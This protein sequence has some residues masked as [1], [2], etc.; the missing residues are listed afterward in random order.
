MT[1]KEKTS[2]VISK[3]EELELSILLEDAFKLIKNDCERFIEKTR[4]LIND[5]HMYEINYFS[6]ECIILEIEFQSEEEANNYIPN[7][8]YDLEITKNKSF[9]NFNVASKLSIE[10]IEKKLEFFY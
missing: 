2:N 4:Y 7:F 6:K 1:I 3:R 10:E 5:K 9:Y 8:E